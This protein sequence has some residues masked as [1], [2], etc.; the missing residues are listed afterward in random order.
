MTGVAEVITDD[1]RLLERFLNPIRSLWKK[2][3]DY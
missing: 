1:V 3:I 2:N